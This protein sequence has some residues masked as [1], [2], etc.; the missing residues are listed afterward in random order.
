MVQQLSMSY[1]GRTM[2]KKLGR[3][4]HFEYSAFHT[5]FKNGSLELELV[6][7]SA[8]KPDEELDSIF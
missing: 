3:S 7:N 5:I 8:Q 6:I 4:F 2:F 1:C